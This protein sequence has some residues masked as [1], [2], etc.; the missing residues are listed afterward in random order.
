[1]LFQR[2]MIIIVYSDTPANFIA[3]AAPERSEW[4]PISSGWNPNVSFPTEAAAA[5]SLDLTWADVISLIFPLLTNVF[6][7]LSSTSS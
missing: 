4:Q 7:F 2:L 1:M 3:I 6:T 5:L